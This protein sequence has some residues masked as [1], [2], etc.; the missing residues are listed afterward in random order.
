[1]LKEM[2]VGDSVLFY[3]SNADPTGVVGIARVSALAEPDGTA[4]NPDSPYYDAKAAEDKP[5]WYCVEVEFVRKLRRAVALGEIRAE[6]ALADMPLL[7]KGQR[8]S[9]Q[10]ASKA[11]FERI[12]KMAE[13]AL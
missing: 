1:M 10:P 9:I 3:H 13:R 2:Q 12:C 11:Q 4:Q 5:I 6:K 7:Q 8:L